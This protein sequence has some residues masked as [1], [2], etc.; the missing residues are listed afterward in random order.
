[1]L[2][3]HSKFAVKSK[4]KLLSSKKSFEIVNPE[5][6]QLLGTGTDVTGF[7]GS[8]LGSTKIEVRD[9]SNNE[10]LFT[11]ERTGVI[12]K[13]DVVM[14]PQGQII[15]RYKSKAFSLSGGFHFYDKDGKHLGEIQGKMLKAEYKFVTPDRATEMGTVSKSWAGMA[16]SLLTGGETY[17]VQISPQFAEDQTAKILILGAT[18]AVESIFKK[19][20]SKAS[21]GG[22]E[23]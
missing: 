12:L 8:L 14:S 20:G 10:L 16:K 9:S 11:V 15:G 4:S 23:E 3:S 22:D 6:E 5:S 2:L 19:K 17:G 13:K 7:L 21:G 18:I 1:M